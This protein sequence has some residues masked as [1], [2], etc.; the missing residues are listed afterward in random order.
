M[1]NPTDKFI[2]LSEKFVEI[3][4]TAQDGSIVALIGNPGYSMDSETS[5]D[6]SFWEDFT[7]Q[8]DFSF[9]SAAEHVGNLEKKV[10]L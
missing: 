4:A 7:E 9:S 5:D 8:H 6:L 3:A 10:G 1:D 2:L